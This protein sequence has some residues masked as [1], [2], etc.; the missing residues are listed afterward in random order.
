[1]FNNNNKLASNYFLSKSKEPNQKR[2]RDNKKG[3]F[4]TQKC[5]K[6]NVAPWQWINTTK[7]LSAS[8]K[9]IVH[10]QTEIMVGTIF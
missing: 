3:L 4:H 8:W 2:H 9:T 6:S 10:E 1:M 7:I 5:G